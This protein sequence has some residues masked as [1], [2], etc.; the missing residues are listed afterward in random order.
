MQKF[1]ERALCVVTLSA[2][3]APGLEIAG[4]LEDPARYQRFEMAGDR[5]FPTKNTDFIL[6]GVDLSAVGW[7]GDMERNLS[8][9]R[10]SVTLITP[11]HIVFAAHYAPPIGS[12]IQFMDAEGNLHARRLMGYEV[13]HLPDG[14]STDAGVG[15]LDASLPPEVKPVSIGPSE[16]IDFTG[17]TLYIYGFTGRVGTNMLTPVWD[18][19]YP[20]APYLHTSLDRA[21]T[22]TALGQS[23]DSGSP[24]FVMQEGEL[25]LVGI[26]LIWAADTWLPTLRDD[27]ERI[28][29]AGGESLSIFGSEPAGSACAADFNLDAALDANDIAAFVTAFLAGDASANLDDSSVGLD[30]GDIMAFVLLYQAGCP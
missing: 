1:Y 27:L 30:M 24:T 10:R 23:G 25:V 11:R 14:R 16:A 18:P 15:V 28:V 17:E 19:S 29:G 13:A 7:V 22:G 5:Y 21:P 2:V 20:F 9:V 26:R 8:S 3:S 4:Y 12:T 6:N